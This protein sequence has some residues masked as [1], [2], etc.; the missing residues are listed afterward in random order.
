MYKENSLIVPLTL[1]LQ[2]IFAIKKYDKK[3]CCDF[4]ARFFI[5]LAENVVLSAE[6]AGY[7][8]LQN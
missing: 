7:S 3:L 8:V 2:N 6:P 1:A 5:D 4:G